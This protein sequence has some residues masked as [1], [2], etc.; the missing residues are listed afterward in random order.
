MARRVAWFTASELRNGGAAS[1]SG[2][3][4]NGELEAMGASPEVS[5][6]PEAI[7]LQVPAPGGKDADRALRLFLNVLRRPAFTPGALQTDKGR[8]IGDLRRV[9]ENRPRLLAREFILTLYTGDHSL[10]RPLTAADVAAIRRD[11]LLTHHRSLFHPNNVLLAVMGD[12]WREEMTANIEA[13]L[14]A[15]PAGAF[16]LP[17]LPLVPSRFAPGVYVIPRRIEQ[18]SLSVGHLGVDRLNP[19]GTPSS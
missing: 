11:D 2:S 12:F 6:C 15:W 17:A 18:A 1:L 10:G 4:L 7:S 14:A 13:R 8:M 19:T 9:A 3:A 5:V 16:D